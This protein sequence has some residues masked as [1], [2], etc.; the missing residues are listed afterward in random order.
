MDPIKDFRLPI[1]SLCNWFHQDVVTRKREEIAHLIRDLITRNTPETFELP[2]IEFPTKD[3]KILEQQIE[4][5]SDNVE[6][7]A[8]DDDEYLPTEED[9]K[10]L[11]QNGAKEEVKRVYVTKKRSLDKNDSSSSENN[12]K[13]PKLHAKNKS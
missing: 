5:E 11:S 7:Q 2:E 4:A 10:E 9:Y 6:G 13:A 3:G 12:A 1:K 8:F